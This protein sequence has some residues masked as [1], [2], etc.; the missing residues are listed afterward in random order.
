MSGSDAIK[1]WRWTGWTGTRGELGPPLLVPYVQMMLNELREIQQRD[2][3]AA[4]TVEP[5]ATYLA[6]KAQIAA[7]E[8]EAAEAKRAAC[9][10]LGTDAAEVGKVWE[11]PGVGSVQ[12]TKG[13]RSL[14][15]NRAKLAKAGVSA[16]VLDACT[17]VSGGAPVIRISA[18]D[19]E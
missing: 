9:E 7:L 4:A 6:L 2:D 15:L 14:K 13:R 18:E 17:E 19:A 5:V 3:L 11:F 16:D 8:A 12:K 10:M 1:K